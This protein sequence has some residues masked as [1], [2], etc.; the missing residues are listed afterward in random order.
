[1]MAYVAGPL[2][3]NDAGLGQGDLLAEAI[4][5]EVEGAAAIGAG[6][7][8]QARRPGKTYRSRWLR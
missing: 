3:H 2:T 8:A 4:E 5:V 6:M 1:M 7:V